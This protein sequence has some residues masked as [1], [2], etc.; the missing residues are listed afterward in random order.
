MNIKFQIVHVSKIEKITALEWFTYTDRIF[1][2]VS[3]FAFIGVLLSLYMKT[4]STI[5][6]ILI[7]FLSFVLFILIA[8]ISLFQIFIKIDGELK[9]EIFYNKI[10]YALTKLVNSFIGLFLIFIFYIMISPFISSF[11]D[12]M[13]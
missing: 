4:K 13:R 2:I 10:A 11:I 5:C 9:R 7:I 8:K 12:Q 3:W 1:K 6:L